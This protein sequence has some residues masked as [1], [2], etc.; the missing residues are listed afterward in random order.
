M[1]GKLSEENC[2]EG[3]ALTAR[4]RLSDVA[5]AAGVS[6]MT[7]TRVLRAP[8]KV[9]PETRENVQ[10]VLR[11]TG[12]TPDLLARGLASKRSGL[13]A[14]IV[15]VLTNSL[16]AEIV[17]G[18]TNALA[19]QGLHVVLGVS[20]FQLGEEEELVKAFL[21]RRVDAIYLSGVIRSPASRTILLRSG[22][23]VVEGGNLGADPIDMAVGHPN[24]AGAYAM[25]RHLVERGYDPIGYIGV[26]ARDND[27][28][29]D[30]RRG[31]ETALLGAGRTPDPELCVE[32]TLD[33]T[34][35]ARAMA[36]LLARPTR[37]RA[38][39]CYSDVL[40]AGAHFE[41]QRRGI[42]IP[43]GL[44]IAGYDDLEI[45]RQITPALTTLRVPC[46]E[47]GERAGQL[48]CRRLAGEQVEERIVNTGFELVVREST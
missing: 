7:V 16:I 36:E 48:I 12:Y 38:V 28:A 37:V 17:Q 9:A 2:P 6:T 29:M 33:L 19:R 35:G 41:C 13:V 10:R 23:P 22:I 45:A 40:A 42:P 34:G 24:L 31:F 20:D 43:D 30:R 4:P 3:S 14:V 32:T 44:A 25:T 15:P 5:R 1:E 46:Y 39:F 18:L 21:S 26:Q 27:R 11:E 47:I 8:E